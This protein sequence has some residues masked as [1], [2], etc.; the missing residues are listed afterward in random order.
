MGNDEDEF[1]NE[2]MQLMKDYYFLNK[3]LIIL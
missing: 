2:Y 1:I 3:K